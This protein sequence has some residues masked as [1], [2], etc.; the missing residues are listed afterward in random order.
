MSRNIFNPSDRNSILERVQSL[1]AKA[2]ARWG[3]MD[4]NQML[5]HA[6][7]QI[8]VALGE[9]TCRPTGT[10]FHRTLAKWLILGGLPFP[11]GRTQTM[12]EISQDKE[13]TPPKGF[14]GDKKILVETIGKIAKAN[15][16]GEFTA[17]PIFGE[18]NNKEWGRLV[19]LHLDHH[20]KQFGS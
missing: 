11:R 14:E 8:K 18:M 4:A 2:S 7:D 9:I 17:H 5:C 1:D 13:G 3:K 6:A 10:I 16:E 19:W 20:L 15:A 12:P